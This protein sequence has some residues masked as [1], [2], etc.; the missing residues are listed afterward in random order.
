MHATTSALGQKRVKPALWVRVSAQP[1]SSAPAMAIQIHGIG[2]AAQKWS[3][4][5]SAA[6]P[7]SS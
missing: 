6:S 5:R 1:I 7:L 4:A 2:R 3:G